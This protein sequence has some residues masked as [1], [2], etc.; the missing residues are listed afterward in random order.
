LSERHGFNVQV[1]DNGIGSAWQ[2][3]IE[4]DLGDD[5]AEW[6]LLNITEYSGDQERRQPWFENG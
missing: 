4:W 6:T 2:A 5:K 3:W 1:V